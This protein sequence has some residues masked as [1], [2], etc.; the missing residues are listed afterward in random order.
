MAN[1]WGRHAVSR[2]PAARMSDSALIE[3]L[4]AAFATR[5]PMDRLGVL[6]QAV[7]GRIV[8][9]SSFGL[10]DQA[11]THCIAA[12]NPDIEIVTLDTGRMYPETYTLWAETEQ[13]Y[14]LRVAPFYPDPEDL[15]ELVKAQGINGFYASVEQRHACCHV[16][17]VVPLAKALSGAAVWITG[18][19]GDAS[20]NRTGM[21]PVECDAACGL[22][23]FN[24]L[25]DWT[26]A[27]VADFAARENIPTNPLHGKGF[28]SIGCAPCTRAIAEG[29]PERAGRWWW[30]QDDQKECGLHVD[31]DGRLVRAASAGSSAPAKV[32]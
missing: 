27:E 11:I 2:T 32:R 18:L 9:T 13:R 6:S 26:R 14:G 8:F 28:V 7:Q 20:G 19:R 4:V 1:D 15:A 23:K 21:Q 5:D 3:H 17:K 24:P 29:E 12:V 22:I 16:R 30:E 10:E 31:S 25:F